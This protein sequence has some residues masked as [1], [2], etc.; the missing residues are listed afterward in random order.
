[1]AIC[2]LEVESFLQHGM[3]RW[4]GGITSDRHM[5]ST[6]INILNSYS[7]PKH[8]R[9]PS[10]RTGA[11]LDW[12]RPQCRRRLEEVWH[13]ATTVWKC[14]FCATSATC[15]IMVNISTIDFLKSFDP[16]LIVGDS[17]LVSAVSWGTSSLILEKR[18]EATA[19]ICIWVCNCSV[20][21]CLV[22]W[23]YIFV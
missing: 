5:A 1:M 11:H 6:T 18:E 22:I 10:D 2:I 19:H 3:I 9:L 23:W 7:Y 14:V 12:W 15:F 4:R 17:V 20:P 21:I 8:A 16:S 13:P